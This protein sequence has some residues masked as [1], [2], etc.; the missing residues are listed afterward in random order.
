MMRLHKATA[1][2]ER[3]QAINDSLK[4]LTLGRGIALLRKAQGFTQEV[5]AESL[6]VTAQAVSKWENNV[7][8]S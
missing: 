8:H 3:N 2:A 1:H 4:E 6:D 7:S 5:L